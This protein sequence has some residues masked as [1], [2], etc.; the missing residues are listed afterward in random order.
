AAITR[1]ATDNRVTA[2]AVQMGTGDYDWADVQELQSA[3]Q[4]FKDSGKPTYVYADSYGDLYPGMAEYYLATAFDEIW[5]QPIGTVAITGFQV[6]VPYFKKTLERLGINPQIEKRGD[7]KTAPEPAMLEHMSE[8]QRET[9]HGILASMMTD[10][11]DAV[12]KAR[13]LPTDR[14]GQLIDGAPYTADEAKERMLID[15][16]GYQDELIQKLIPNAD[17]RDQDLVN[18]IDYYDATSSDLMKT[19]RQKDMPRLGESKLDKASKGKNAVALVYV[20]GM[21]V[22]G[23]AGDQGAFD[24]QS[25][26]ADDIAW[27]IYD[28]AEDDDVSAIVIRVDSPGG[29]PQASET[30]RRAIEVAKDHGKYVVVSMGSEAASGGYWIVV[31]ADRIYAQ[32]GTLT[33]SIGVFGGKPDLSE[34]W[35]KLDVNWDSVKLGANAGMWSPNHAYDEEGWAATGRIMD[36]I[37]AS[38]IARVAKGRNFSDDVVEGM[39]GGRVWTGRQ[40]KE[41]GL[42]DELGGLDTA[43]IDVANHM[44][45]TRDELDI[46]VLPDQ[47]NPLQEVFGWLNGSAKIF[48]NFNWLIGAFVRESHPSWT[49]TYQQNPL[50]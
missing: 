3:I 9:L 23:T 12:S 49:L 39:A 48:S 6:E 8:P 5:M 28:A 16:V 24:S 45:V 13:G 11:F 42:I 25:A 4:V 20:T 44:G 29:S 47:P 46:F 32:P 27:G 37:Y 18:L 31:D 40:A 38:F 22:P 19:V 10:F 26:L 33:G 1:A 43:L 2:L 21:I 17:K 36:D 15:V 50:R 7:Y 35:S 34:M 41:R 30:I 14:V